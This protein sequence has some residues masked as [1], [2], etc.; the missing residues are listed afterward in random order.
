MFS[1]CVEKNTAEDTQELKLFKLD[2]IDIV[3]IL[4]K[5]PI[6]YL[7]YA[8]S[9]HKN[10]KFIPETLDKLVTKKKCYNKTS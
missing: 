10:L 6:D 4:K 7:E 3:S 5:N 9:L 8:N 1:Y 2:V